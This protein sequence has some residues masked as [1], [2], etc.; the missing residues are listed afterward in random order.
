MKKLERLWKSNYMKVVFTQTYLSKTKN[1]CLQGHLTVSDDHIMHY[2]NKN[3]IKKVLINIY[4]LLPT[5][6]PRTPLPR[7]PLPRLNRQLI[8]ASP[9]MI[10]NADS[11]L[12]V[13]FNSSSWRSKG[14]IGSVKTFLRIIKGGR[15]KID[16]L[17]DMSLISTGK[18]E[19]VDPLS[20]KM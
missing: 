15:K 5:P 19:G 2:N 9:L 11:W 6:P 16:I 17:G 14:I 1:V 10:L 20:A 12:S 7:T 8:F 18:G 4:T 13:S 3:Q